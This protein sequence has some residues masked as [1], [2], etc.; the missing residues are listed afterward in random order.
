MV[1]QKYAINSILSIKAS[2]EQMQQFKALI[3]GQNPIKINAKTVFHVKFTKWSSHR[4][5]IVALLR[6]PN[7]CRKNI[8]LAK[9][10]QSIFRWVLTRTVIHK[11]KKTTLKEGQVTN[12]GHFYCILWIHRIAFGWWLFIVRFANVNSIF[13]I[14]RWTSIH[15]I[16]TTLVIW[17]SKH[18]CKPDAMLFSKHLPI[19]TASSSPPP[20]LAAI[21]AQ[22]RRT[23]TRINISAI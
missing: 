17:L 12:N 3:V 4:F 15:W 14:V 1:L 16:S 23:H 8:V 21:N 9:R 18:H 7:A 20:P 2:S 19:S 10:C 22:S 13:Q 11:T 5:C 6:Q